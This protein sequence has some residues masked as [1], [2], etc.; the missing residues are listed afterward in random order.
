MLN[1]NCARQLF[2]TIRIVCIYLAR[3]KLDLEGFLEVLLVD[4]AN[5]LSGVDFRV[6]LHNILVELL[7]VGGKKLNVQHK[8]EN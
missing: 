8:M 3:D 2:S 6:F 1:L 7:S 5:F 4:D